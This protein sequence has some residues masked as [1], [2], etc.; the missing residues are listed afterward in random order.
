MK[1]S[2]L[3]ITMLLISLTVIGMYNF[4]GDLSSGSAFNVQDINSSYK[5]TYDKIDS[6]NTNME[7]VQN[8][9]LNVS[10]KEDKSF[11]TGTW[12]TFLLS[13]DVVLGAIGVT[14]SSVSVGS[15]LIA[16]FANDLGIGSTVLAVGITLLIIGIV[17]ALVFL[18]VKRTW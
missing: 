9:L 15:D 12:D 16:N 5:T 2:A 18:I 7:D 8:R 3:I 1:I 6:L 4:M 11:F 17:G 10:P 13:R 14:G